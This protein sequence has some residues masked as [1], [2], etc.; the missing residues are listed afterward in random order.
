MLHSLVNY[1]EKMGMSTEPGFKAKQ[2]RWMVVCSQD[3]RFLQVLELGDVN[4]RSNKGRWFAACPDLSQGELIAGGVARSHFLV[5]T[6]AVVALFGET[7]AK[8]VA[9]HAYF[10]NAIEDASRTVPDLTPLVKCLR[11]ESALAAIRTQFSASKVKPGDKVSLQT[12]SFC[13]LESD[14][15]HQ[16]WRLRRS[17]PAQAGAREKSAPGGVAAL[18]RDFLT[19]AMVRPVPTQPKINGLSAVGGLPTG[20]VVVG[21]DK[22]AFCSYGLEQSANAAMSEETAAKY[23]ASLNNLIDKTGRRLAGAL[24]VHWFDKAPAQGEDPFE[25]L[26]QGSEEVELEAQSRAAALLDAVRSGARPDLA[27]N[28][29]HALTLSGAAGRVMVRD[30]MEGSFE[31]LVANVRAW[32]DDLLIVRRDGQG[33]AAAPKFMAVL[34]ATVRDLKDLPAPFVAK[35]WRTAVHNEPIPRD[36]LAR[37]LARVRVDIISDQ[38]FNHA[39]M[40]LLKAYHARIHR[41]AGGNMSERMKATYDSS[42]PSP[43]YHCGALMAVIG[44]LQRSALGDVGAG[45]I[46]RYFAA[47]S[48]TPALVLGRLTR[49]SQFHL[50]KLDAGL[51]YWYE[52]KIADAWGNMQGDPPRTLT[53]EEQSL[54]ALGYYQQM[55][56]LRAP[57]VKDSTTSSSESEANNE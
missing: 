13:P 21:F 24:V 49:T 5:E 38:S 42:H 31:Q 44:A 33:T 6:A 55:A 10:V 8:T 14:A 56:Q 27:G 16:W 41:N 40:G 22:D 45:V 25:F 43:A 19:G 9:K 23:S 53:L 4:D 1:A 34:G 51:A 52:G 26:E 37:A 18:M 15:W 46:Q 47:A 57:K 28:S 2:V 17:V 11:N 54:F 7:E 48:T 30:W 3:G 35:M 50:N 29:Y 20:D 32:F 12:G 39:R 36:A